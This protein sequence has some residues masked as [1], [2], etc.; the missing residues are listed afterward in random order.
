MIGALLLALSLQTPPLATTG[1]SAYWEY[2]DA[3]LAVGPIEVFLVC[4]DGQATATCTHVPAST[5]VVSAAGTK[6]YRWKLPPLLAGSHVVNVQACTAGAN[7]CT[8]GA[9]LRFTFQAMAEPRNLRIGG[10]L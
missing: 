9:T 8:A 10:G 1:A 2:D 7:D 3:D 4:L 6:T 5:G